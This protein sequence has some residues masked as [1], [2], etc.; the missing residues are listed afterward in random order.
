[1]NGKSR[2][3]VEASNQPIYLAVKGDALASGD[4]SAASRITEL[5]GH[6]VRSW[7]QLAHLDEDVEENNA[8]VVSP[9]LLAQSA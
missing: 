8:R 5:T 6:A 4:A 2:C 9:A 7:R 3:A 1:M